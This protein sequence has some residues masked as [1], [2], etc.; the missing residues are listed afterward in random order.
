MLIDTHCHINMMIKKDFDIL[1]SDENLQIARTIIEQSYDND[2]KILLNVGTSLIES[3]NSVK[4]SKKFDNVYS[5]IG[6]HPNDLNDNFKEELNKLSKLLIDKENNKIVAIGECGLDFHYPNYNLSR[7]IEAFKIQIDLA[8]SNNMPLIVHSRDAYQETLEILSKFYS[9]SHKAVGTIH[10]FS[11]DLSFAKEAIALGFKIGIDA[12]ITYPKNNGL[13]D[14]TK[15]INLTNI[16]LETDAPFLPPQIIR[17]KQNHPL[18]I[19]TIA[20]FIANLIGISYEEVAKQTTDNAQ[21]IFK[22]KTFQKI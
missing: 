10:C 2:V 6:I 15:S 17:G 1:L 11:Y 14:V 3:I 22:F 19:K 9:N 7:Q 13:R 20:N 8:L 21:K 5:S 4:L 18:Y 16:L 12:P